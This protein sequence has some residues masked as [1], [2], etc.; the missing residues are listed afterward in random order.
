[1]SNLSD[2]YYLAG[3]MNG[4]DESNL[5][6][7]REMAECRTMHNSSWSLQRAS[8]GEQPYWATVTLA[9]ILGQIGLPGGGFGVGYGAMN[10]VGSTLRRAGR[11]ARLC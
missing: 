8:L 1:L 9:A 6:A 4:A 2:K 5:S 3:D 7:A 10:S 11:L